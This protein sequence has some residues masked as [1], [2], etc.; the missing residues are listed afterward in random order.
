MSH[1]SAV[2]SARMYELWVDAR[3]EIASIIVHYDQS[4]DA[5]EALERA[6][7]A[8]PPM[9]P[10]NGIQIVTEEL[11]ESKRN[12]NGAFTAESLAEIGVKWPP[13]NG[14]QKEILGKPL[15]P[16]QLPAKMQWKRDRNRLATKIFNENPKLTYQQ[17]VNKA[18]Q[19]MGDSYRRS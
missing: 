7:K 10:V 8:M 6:T 19:M 2:S 11:I 12:E 13:R 9:P 3:D 18:S 4:I 15:K 14:W 5:N 17:A 16:I 1:D